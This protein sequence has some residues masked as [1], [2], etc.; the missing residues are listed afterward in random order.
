MT[1][2]AMVAGEGGLNATRGCLSRESEINWRLS[3][4]MKSQD[5]Q[6]VR[7][8]GSSGGAVLS[9][10]KSFG[11]G[12]EALRLAAGC[13]DVCSSPLESGSGEQQLEEKLCGTM[14]ARPRRS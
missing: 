5:A 3:K 10:L 13:L 4:T 6:D 9:E 1:V 11:G 8:D 7:G 12:V 2:S 14:T